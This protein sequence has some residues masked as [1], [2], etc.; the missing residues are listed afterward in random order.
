MQRIMGRTQQNHPKTGT[1]NQRFFPRK[2]RDPN[3]MDIDAMSFD[4]RKKLNGKCFHC[5][6]PGHISKEY[7][8]KHEPQRKMNGMEMQKHV[9]SLIAGLEEEERENF[10]KEAEDAGF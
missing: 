8:L 3:T 6:R 9:R 2:E 5:K 4:E 1:S 10:W 7:P